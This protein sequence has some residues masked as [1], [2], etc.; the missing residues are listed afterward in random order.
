MPG[1]QPIHLSQMGW[2]ET[3]SPG[4]A[5]RHVRRQL[6][7]GC[8]PERAWWPYADQPTTPGAPLLAETRCR[9]PPCCGPA[10]DMLDSYHAVKHLGHDQFQ[11]SDRDPGSKTDMQ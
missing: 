7:G 3:G 4:P 11:H 6:V 8:L 10:R 2:Y 1:K 5:E 9:R